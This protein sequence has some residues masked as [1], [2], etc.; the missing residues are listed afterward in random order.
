MKKSKSALF[1]CMILGIL[2]SSYFVFTEEP[3][4]MRYNEPTEPLTY[5]PLYVE[6]R[7]S[8]HLSSLMYKNLVGT[9]ANFN[10]RPELLESLTPKVPKPG[11]YEFTLKSD[12]KWVGYDKRQ[13][14]VVELG[15]LTPGD[16]VYTSPARNAK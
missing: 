15:R 12:V 14:T 11:V 16:V 5:D 8:L 4:T 9:D 1:S 7:V 2:S 6:D 3:K 10:L 13:R